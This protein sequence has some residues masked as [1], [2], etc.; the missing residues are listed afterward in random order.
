[1]VNRPDI[2]DRPDIFDAHCHFFSAGFFRTLGRDLREPAPADAAVTLPDRLGWDQPGDDTALAARWA[3]ELDRHGVGGAMLIASVPGDEAAVAEA[4][5]RYPARFAAAS[6]VNPNAPDASARAIRAFEEQDLR[7]LCLFPAM[8]QVRLHDQRVERLVAIAAERDKAVFV[9]CGMLSI[10][11]RK[12][13]GIPSVYDLRF[14]DPLAVARLANTYPSANFII[15]HFGAGMLRV[16]LMAMD[17][18]PNIY[19][20][21][22]SSNSWMKYQAR[23]TLADVFR[24]VLDVAGPNRIL[25][26]TDSSFFP[27]GWQTPIFDAQ[28]AIIDELV[29]SADDRAAILGGNARRILGMP[30]AAKA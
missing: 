10:G 30:A 8:H 17:A 14:G 18:A 7:C 11:V 21:T 3:G 6:M 29:P 5:R 27:R 9:H 13:L 4:A 26:G 23:L 25:F 12:K 1:M 22:S 2:S 19:V 16:T 24:Q 28:L 20:D 15:P